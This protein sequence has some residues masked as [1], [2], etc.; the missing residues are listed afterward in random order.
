MSRYTND[1]TT[2]KKASEISK[3]V[4]DFMVKEG[5]LA[6]PK[7]KNT[8]KKGFGIMTG[9]QLIKVEATDGKAHIEA[10]IKMAILPGVYAGEMGVT[11]FFGFALKNA[12]RN[13]L[14]RLEKLI[15]D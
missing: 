10:W 2:K 5:F 8:W 15:I 14:V 4:N 13:K 6:W 12:L 3:I 7:E 11:G 1:L 9:P